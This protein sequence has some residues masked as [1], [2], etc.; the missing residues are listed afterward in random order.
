MP[1][2]ILLG[3]TL[4]GGKAELDL[5]ELITGRTLLCSISR[6]GKTWT[7]RRIVEQVFGKTGIIIVDV[8]G[9]YATLRDRYP[10]LI[11]GKD[12]PVVPE[13]AEFL[14]DQI[15]EHDLSA[16]VDGSD[17][18]LDIATFQEFLARFIER[19]IAIETK[20]RKPYLWILEEADELAPET[21]I[22]RSICLN[23]VRKLVKKGGKRGLGTLVLTQRPAFVSKFVISQCPNKLIGRTEWPDDLAVLR[24]FGRIPGRL[25]DPE[26]KDPHALKNLKKGQF[27]VAGDFIGK[28]D[29]VKVG[30]VQ[31]KHLG[32]TPELIPPAPKEL[33][34]ILRQL[35][36][37]LPAIIL[38]KLAPAVPK[39]AE[40]EAR[41]RE[42]FEAQWQARLA[43]K[44]K[45]LASIKNRLE[46]KYETEI[47]DLKRKLDEAVRH[48]TLKGGI[49]DL[50]LHP[51][52]QKNL[53]KLSDKQRAFVELLET[54]GPQDP[55]RCSLFLEINPKSVPSF[56][57]EINRK[58]PKL[59]E[60][61]GGRYISR[62]AK[63]FPVTE[64]AKAEAKESQR[65]QAEVAQLKQQLE[66]AT[67]DFQRANERRAQFEREVQDLRAQQRAG[68]A[69]PVSTELPTQLPTDSGGKKPEPPIEQPRRI[70]GSS[71]T[72]PVD[73]TLNRVLRD[74]KVA[75]S[76]EVFDVDES[77]WEGK[78]LARG[79]EG[80]FKEPR[81]LGSVVTEL[82]R[83]Y[84]V[85]D[86]GGNR[87]SVGKAL[88]VLV[89][90]GV[91]DRQGTPG[92]WE[93]S[94]SPEFRDRVKKHILEVN[95]T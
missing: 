81:R 76:H 73:V 95:T 63:L 35:S 72:M 88:A 62:L 41:I 10:L 61:Q 7:A 14:A 29:L 3:E 53:A 57:Y 77:L 19:F 48:A 33:K 6:W 20:A 17:P 58:I 82:V 65:L 45:E 84:D 18:Q 87:E 49:S 90:K 83:R 79:L 74:F 69:R 42:K 26:S 11:I 36:E 25:A 94:E 24:K 51:L 55:E 46:A 8:E 80:F 43:R 56:V 40:V 89:S 52:V 86:S 50:L 2:K 4:R 27:Y 44:D 39:V 9:E 34:D 54:K 23:Q 13:S 60:N 21:G 92:Q 15:L 30:P 91:L 12:V 75:T 85:S 78:I 59:I 71:Q 70:P 93:Y 22:A 66:R 38:E 68:S 47:A 37:K 67:V 1:D 28:D 64:E 32:A 5:Q 31:T 16:I